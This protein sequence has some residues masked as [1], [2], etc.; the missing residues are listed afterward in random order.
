MAYRAGA[1]E[2]QSAIGSTLSGEHTD[3]ARERSDRLPSVIGTYCVRYLDPFL[4][5]AVRLERRRSA[6]VLTAPA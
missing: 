5:A 1:S 6:A 3:K 2:S 4:Q